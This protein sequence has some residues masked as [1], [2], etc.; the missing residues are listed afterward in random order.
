MIELLRNRKIQFI[1]LSKPGQK[2]E[3]VI[4]IEFHFESDFMQDRLE[5][6]K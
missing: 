2:F 4:V 5:D 3:N 6:L 1:K